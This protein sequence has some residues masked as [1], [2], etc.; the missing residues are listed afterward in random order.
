MKVTVSCVP[1]QFVGFAAWDRVRSWPVRVQF[2]TPPTLAGS[3]NTYSAVSDGTNPELAV[4]EEQQHIF[5]H[6]QLGKF[7]KRRHEIIVSLSIIFVYF[8]KEICTKFV[9]WLRAAER[10]KHKCSI[11]SV[12]QMSASLSPAAAGATDRLCRPLLPPPAH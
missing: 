11:R 3:A 12:C 1:V 2:L 9:H 10:T 5:I 7:V 4:C 6:R 8:G